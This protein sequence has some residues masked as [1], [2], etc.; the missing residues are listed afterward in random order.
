[1]DALRHLADHEQVHINVAGPEMKQDVRRVLSDAGAVESLRKKSW[2]S[3]ASSN[4]RIIPYGCRIKWMYNGRSKA[5][6]G[7]DGLTR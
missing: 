2:S 4:E 7:G 5:S 1:M 6:S 3:R